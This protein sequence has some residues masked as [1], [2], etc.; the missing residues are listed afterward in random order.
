MNIKN[1]DCCIGS[2]KVGFGKW[3]TPIGLTTSQC[4]YCEFCYNNGCIDKSNVY[5]ATNI[6]PN[7]YNSLTNCNCDC[8]NQS[9]HERVVPIKCPFCNIE[10]ECLLCGAG[11]CQDCE[12]AV[13]YFFY[14]LCDG[15]SYRNKSCY[16]CGNDINTGNSYITSVKGYIEDKYSELEES[17]LYGVL[18]PVIIDKEKKNYQEYLDRI[19]N[20]YSDKTAAEMVEILVE[21]RRNHYAK[22]TDNNKS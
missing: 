7:K 2:A 6:K 18:S 11:K 10:A 4:T 20:L 1:I 8:P 16:R 14:K 13:P 12:T 5:E 22:H 9:N 19:K 17:R 15:C 3:Y 21:E